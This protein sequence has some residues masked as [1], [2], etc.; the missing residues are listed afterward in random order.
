MKFPTN[1]EKI[2]LEIASTRGVVSQGWSYNFWR[3]GRSAVVVVWGSGS[4]AVT[5]WFRGNKVC[6][7]SDYG[8]YAM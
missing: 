4:S 5:V 6:R 7:I 3:S 8:Y 2:A 1:R